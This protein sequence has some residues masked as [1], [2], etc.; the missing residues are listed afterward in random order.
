VN[1]EIAVRFALPGGSVGLPVEWSIHLV[2]SVFTTR[3]R[4]GQMQVYQVSEVALDGGA[5]IIRAREVQVGEAG[6][7][8]APAPPRAGRI[9]YQPLAEGQRPESVEHFGHV[10][11]PIS[12]CQ[13]C[14][15][16]ADYL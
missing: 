6:P 14:E 9:V 5:M 11:H 16:L 8:P 2:G 7:S 12:T 13:V 4:P 15:R 1:D 10:M 3:T